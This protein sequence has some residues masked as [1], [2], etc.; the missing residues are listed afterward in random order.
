MSSSSSSSTSTTSASAKAILFSSS[1]S[2][3][4]SPLVPVIDA[5]TPITSSSSTSDDTLTKKRKTRRKGK[6]GRSSVMNDANDSSCEKK[7]LPKAIV[8]APMNAVTVE[9][10]DDDDNQI[11]G[12]EG[13]LSSMPPLAVRHDG[14]VVSNARKKR[15]RRRAKRTALA[16]PTYVASLSSPLSTTTPTS[17]NTT[18]TTTSVGAA[19]NNDGTMDIAGDATMITPEVISTAVETNDASSSSSSPQ[20]RQRTNANRVVV[21][22]GDGRGHN[23]ISHN[24]NRSTRVVGGGKD[25]ECLRRIKREWKD[26]VKMG[27]AYDWMNMRTVSNQRTSDHDDESS[28]KHNNFIRIGPYGKNLLRWHFSVAGPANSVYSQGIYHGAILLPRN[29]PASP[30]RIRLLTP[31]GRFIVDCDV[32]LTASNYHPESWTPRWTVVSLVQALRLHMLTSPSEIGGMHASDE[33]RREFAMASREW[34]SRDGLVE[35]GRMV[36]MGVFPPTDKEYH[37]D[38]SLRMNDDDNSNNNK[39]EQ[40]REE[41]EGEVIESVVRRQN[42]L[43]NITCSSEK[44]TVESIKSSAVVSK[45]NAKLSGVKHAQRDSHIQ[46]HNIQRRKDAKNATTSITTKKSSAKIEAKRRRRKERVFVFLLKR[47]ILELIK[48]PLRIISTLL[49]ILGELL[50]N[51]V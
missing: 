21:V 1:P 38:D 42:V 32:C 33:K 17:I 48:I 25:G 49:K 50:C 37:D 5:I 11:T 28:G 30:P 22:G 35:H 26:A 2:S 9:N 43:D 6:R 34:R 13:F 23:T 12:G 16:A 24:K 44:E 27:I 31:S 10:I 41:G 36:T 18:S 40:Q 46:S 20:K 3:T 4:H 47:I 15:K 19:L 45:L 51:L 14:I 7:L 39:Q 8:Y 29:Y